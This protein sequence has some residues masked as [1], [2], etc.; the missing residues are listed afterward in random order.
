MIDNEEKMQILLK[1][2][3]DYVDVSFPN[4]ID[5]MEVTIWLNIFLELIRE[6]RFALCREKGIWL[7]PNTFK[8]ES[9]NFIEVLRITANFLE[10]V[11]GHK[12]VEPS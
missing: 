8:I 1:E 2:I 10:K 5:K 12:K 11:G 7:I 3:W 6:P 4:E 9:K